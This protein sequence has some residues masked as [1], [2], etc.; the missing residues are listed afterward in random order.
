M[1]IEELFKKHLFI[2]YSK[3]IFT[4]DGRFFLYEKSE[5]L[6]EERGIIPNLNIFCETFIEYVLGK[7]DLNKEED[8]IFI[9]KNIFSNI[10]NCFFKN[11]QISIEYKNA[12]INDGDGRYRHGNILNEIEDGKLKF[13]IIDISI[14]SDKYNFRE[15]LE[16]IFSHEITHAF[17]NFQRLKNEQMSLFDANKKDGYENNK[18]W[19]SSKYDDRLMPIEAFRRIIYFLNKSEM[20]AYASTLK[21]EMR[22]NIE[23]YNNVENVSDLL[24]KCSI[25]EHY[26]AIKEYLEY[27]LNLR[28]E[29]TKQEI[30]DEYNRIFE[31]DIKNYSKLKQILRLRFERRVEKMLNKIS[32]IAF[33]TYHEYKTGTTV[34]PTGIKPIKKIIQ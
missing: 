17:D 16:K 30:L 12:N 1:N 18:E 6:F 3:S 15:L 26:N 27:F 22:K 9:N 31:K 25:Y 13:L 23:K 21:S 2:E 28:D 10:Q 8:R 32:K 11:V 33:D 4:K 19:F 24:K 20:N 34:C 7:I 29:K 14:S 5:K